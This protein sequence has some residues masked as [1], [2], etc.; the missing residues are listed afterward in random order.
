M[1]RPNWATTSTGCDSE[2][3]LTA[4]LGDISNMLGKVMERLDRTESKIESMERSL[5]SQ[6]SSSGA[7]GSEH[8][9]KVPTVVRV[10]KLYL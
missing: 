3:N 6:P 9:R 2:S 7:S 10:S 5:N 4:V 1:Y 8:R